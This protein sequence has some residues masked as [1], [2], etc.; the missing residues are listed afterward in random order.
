MMPTNY[1]AIYDLNFDASH[2]DNLFDMPERN[3]DHYLS[4]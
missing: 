1:H 4:P 3:V 2:V